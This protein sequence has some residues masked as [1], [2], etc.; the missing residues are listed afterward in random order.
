MSSRPDLFLQGSLP[1]PLQGAQ[2]T[3]A[4]RDFLL[5]SDTHV[6]FL[7]AQKLQMSDTPPAVVL[8]G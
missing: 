2:S 4:V 3:L 7:I 5:V 8:L 1:L 6:K